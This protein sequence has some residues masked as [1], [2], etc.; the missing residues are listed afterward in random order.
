MKGSFQASFHSMPWQVENVAQLR[1]PNIIRLLGY[2]LDFDAGKE[3]HEQVLI[4][5]FAPNG[6]LETLMAERGE[7]YWCLQKDC[8][9]CSELNSVCLSS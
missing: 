4:Y 3:R 8:A 1:H 9:A 2:C 5:E 6:N 7:T